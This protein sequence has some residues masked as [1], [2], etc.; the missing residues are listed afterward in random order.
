MSRP[1]KSDAVVEALRA[2][3]TSG[4]DRGPDGSLVNL[5]DGI[6]LAG[7]VVAY[8]LRQLSMS[9]NTADLA[10]AMRDLAKSVNR[11]ADALG[12]VGG[13]RMGGEGLQR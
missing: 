9:D 6:I 8:G 11:V 7:R 13:D 5:T 1:T 4:K 10:A 12:G 3:L 2:I